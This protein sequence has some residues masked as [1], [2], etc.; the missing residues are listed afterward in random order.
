MLEPVI[1]FFE[2]L[3][4]DFSWRRLFLLAAVLGLAIAT[5]WAYESYTAALHLARTEK[6]LTLLERLVAL[7]EKPAVTT[8]PK[9][10]SIYQNLQAQLSESTAISTEPLLLSPEATKA[11]AAASAWFVLAILVIL[12]GRSRNVPAF[13]SATAVGMLV[14]A[15][16]FVV[17]AAFLPTFKAA[18]VNYFLYPV[19]HV[20]LVVAAI[21]L[22]QRRSKKRAA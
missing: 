5:L 3:I 18:W 9:L 14:L 19:G 15:T 8:D 16:P 20:A 2:R 1:Q 12:A 22:W 11:L 13:T 7:G 17:L 10:S 21:L 4:S 6:E